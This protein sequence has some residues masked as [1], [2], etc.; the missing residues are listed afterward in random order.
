[1]IYLPKHVAQLI[2]K[3][4]LYSVASFWIIIERVKF[5]LILIFLI[6]FSVSLFQN[7]FKYSLLEAN[8]NI[9]IYIY[10]HYL[11]H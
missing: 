6:F 1:M 10:I 2:D 4:K 8:V 9:Y 11:K 7:V 3:N 5:S